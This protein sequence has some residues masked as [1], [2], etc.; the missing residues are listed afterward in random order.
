MA[1]RKALADAFN[2][3]PD[4]AK[5]ATQTA[6]DTVAEKPEPK[7]RAYQAPSRK[8]KKFIGGYFEADVAK[9]LKLLAVEQDATSEGLVKEAV[10]DLFQKYGK[11]RLA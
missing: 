8:G 5:K 1:K 9:Q 2:A 4:A 7:R 6:A 10:N 3:K 11:A